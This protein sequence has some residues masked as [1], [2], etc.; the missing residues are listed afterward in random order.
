MGRPVGGASAVGCG[1]F[2]LGSLVIGIGLVVWLGSMTMSATDGGGDRGGR[3]SSGDTGITTDVSALTSSLEDLTSGGAP[4]EGMEPVGAAL[5]VPGDLPAEGSTTAT[6]TDLA[7][8]PIEL[9]WCLAGPGTPFEVGG[10]DDATTATGTV[11]EDG[12]LS[13]DLPV[14][15]VIT[16]DGT[17]YDCGARAG[18]CALFGHRTSV[19]D[20]ARGHNPDRKSVV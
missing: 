8:G 5:T 15:R 12:R 17:A 10:C 20:R 13:L 14:H 7:P 16:V 6:G 4:V 11:G 3:S 2:G 9:T 18:A 19:V 1:V